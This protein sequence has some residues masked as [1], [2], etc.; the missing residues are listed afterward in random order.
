MGEKHCLF[1]QA[2]IYIYTINTKETKEANHE[3]QLVVMSTTMA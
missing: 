1:A 3:K 2:L